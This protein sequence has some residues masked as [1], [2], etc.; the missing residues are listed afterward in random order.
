MGHLPWGEVEWRQFA[1]DA[2][3]ADWSRVARG[4][5]VTLFAG[6]DSLTSATLSAVA[7]RPYEQDPDADAKVL[8]CQHIAS[9]F[10]RA[11]E[12]DLIHN[13]FDFLPLT[14][15]RPVDTRVAQTIHG[16][17]SE[18]IAPVYRRYDD[19][20]TDVAISEAD[21]H[22]D[23]TYAATVHHGIPI[24]SVPVGSGSADGTLAFFGRIH[25]DKGTDLVIEVARRTGRPLVLA[26]IVQDQAFFDERVAP[27]LDGD[28]VRF[29]GP[30]ASGQRD[31][32]LG[33]VD[34]LLHPVRFAEPFG[35][36]MVE[37][38]ACGTPV[39]AT[40][41]GPVPEV[42]A[43][44]E[45]GFV[46]DDLDAAVVAVDRLGEIDRVACRARV[47]ERFSVDRM[48]E[49]YLRVYEGVLAD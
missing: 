30:V 36:S 32:L 33:S 8:E 7:P 27:H 12:F 1:L 28:R 41:L 47:Q 40:R 46:V 15:S 45:T 48:V 4:I 5:D 26:S 19:R 42:V 24:G 13:H 44:G 43:D 38:M 35:L 2:R 29:L 39:I 49:G 23:L 21:R 11:G 10:E 3:S 25:P 16:L 18:R 20:V 34:A 22:P 6:A 37:A 9:V 17:S 31:E 14:Y